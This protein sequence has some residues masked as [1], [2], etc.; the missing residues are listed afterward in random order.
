MFNKWFNALGRH[1]F[2][3]HQTGQRVRLSIN[4]RFLDEHFIEL[5]GANSFIQ[6][7]NEGPWQ[8]QG[9]NLATMRDRGTFLHKYWRNSIPYRSPTWLTHDNDIEDLPPYLPYLCLLCL[10]WTECEESVTASNAFYQRLDILYPEHDLGHHLAEWD[11]L[12][13]GLAEWTS[14]KEGKHGHFVVERLGRMAHVGIPK[15]QVIF[16]PN[17]IDALP[18]LFAALNLQSRSAPSVN[19][20]RTL[21]QANEA[22][23]VHFLGDAITKLLCSASDTDIGMTAIGI[24]QE[25]LAEWDGSVPR[26]TSLGINGGTMDQRRHFLISLEAIDTGGWRIRLAVEAGAES[27]LIR[28]PFHHWSLKPVHSLVALVCEESG[29]IKD[30]RNLLSEINSP[31]TYKATY[32]IEGNA[33][34]AI[35]FLLKKRKARYFDRWYDN[36]LLECDHLPVAGI[37]YILLTETG[38]NDWT[39]WRQEHGMCLTVADY[40]ETGLPTGWHLICITDGLNKVDEASLNAFPGLDSPTQRNVN[41]IWLSNGTRIPSSVSRKLYAHYDPPLVHINAKS[42]AQLSARGAESFE[43]TPLGNRRG[44][45]PGNVV[46]TFNLN[47]DS[48]ET[49]VVLHINE[50]EEVIAH[51]S[52]G[53]WSDRE[54]PAVQ[55][56]GDLQ[57]DPFGNIGARDGV[58]GMRCPVT[59]NLEPALILDDPRIEIQMA[60]E[61]PAFNLLESLSTK[62]MLTFPDFRRRAMDIAKVEYWTLY[63]ETRWLACLSHIDIKADAYGRWSHVIPLPRQLMLSPWKFGN[64]LQ[65]QLSGCGTKREL[66][67]LIEAAQTLGIEIHACEVGCA[68]A[69]PRIVLRHD[70][71]VAFELVA[72]AANI[73]WVGG[74]APLS[75]AQ[76][77]ESLDNWCEKG[78]IFWHHHEPP[79]HESEY[80]PY[81]YN[82]KPTSENVGYAA[83]YRL[84]TIADRYATGHRCHVLV[85]RSA[86]ME[87]ENRTK[88]AFINDP[89]WAMWKTHLTIADEDDAPPYDSATTIPYFPET[90]SIIVPRALSFPYLLGRALCLSS[91][92]APKRIHNV[93][94]YRRVE[95]KIMPSEAKPYCG[96]CWEFRGVPRAIAEQVAAK[97]S[98]KLKDL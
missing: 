30:A 96:D 84:F 4:R 14:S 51:T 20:L 85:R 98:A 83:P 78:P 43:I 79:Y 57:V 24:I 71:I 65:A 87:N 89:S 25:N 42:D 64:K 82:I 46:R 72:E 45:L 97:L 69:P 16:T 23:T 3:R 55:T 90:S 50:G 12:W 74:C 59:A 81:E 18:G 11:S 66:H 70:E 2:G 44:D 29:Q 75:I 19:K 7:V 56:R 80:T 8:N 6:T 62:G 94:A 13:E 93:P 47:L 37:A 5:G 49:L 76:W 54:L 32:S 88:Y 33:E 68:I 22:K 58:Y 67:D 9:G 77:S 91:G 52:F 39:R 21:I 10:A 63:Q 36:R 40:T 38:Y 61:N 92:F 86:A 95:L 60:L 26:D 28:F 35:T 1:F 73:E 31:T 15:A 53:V 48:G 27:S 17:R 34:T 41:A